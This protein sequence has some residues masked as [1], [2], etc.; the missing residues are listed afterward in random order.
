MVCSHYLVVETD[1]DK[2]TGLLWIMFCDG[3]A[4]RLVFRGFFVYYSLWCYLVW[5]QLILE[6]IVAHFAIKATLC[7]REQ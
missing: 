2:V 1:A 7:R 3:S 5:K 6:S 4:E